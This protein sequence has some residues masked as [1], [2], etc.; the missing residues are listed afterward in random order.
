MTALGFDTVFGGMTALR[1]DTVF[2]GMTAPRFDTVSGERQRR[3]LTQ[4]LGN[5]NAED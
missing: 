3:G 1:F 2:G 5:D 4:Y